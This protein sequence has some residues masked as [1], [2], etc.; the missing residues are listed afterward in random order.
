MKAEC[1]SDDW[2]PSSWNQIDSAANLPKSEPRE[3]GCQAS[4]ITIIDPHWYVSKR[5]ATTQ[6]PAYLAANCPVFLSGDHPF[7]RLD[8]VVLAIL[9]R[10]ADRTF[11]G[12]SRTDPDPAI[13]SQVSYAIEAIDMITEWVQAHYPAEEISRAFA[14]QKS[15]LPEVPYVPKI[16]DLNPKP[17]NYHFHER[18]LPP[19]DEE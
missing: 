12:R 7:Y 16:P 3:P 13:A 17:R 5:L 9:T 14:D 1:E 2:F 11:A 18:Q 15:A 10:A 19:D 8:P 4:V 6:L